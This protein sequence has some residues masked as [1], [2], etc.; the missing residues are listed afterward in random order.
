MLLVVKNIKRGLCV[1]VH[2]VSE[3]PRGPIHLSYA[4][5]DIIM[6]LHYM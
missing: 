2:L 4:F 1:P 3:V 6:F 5:A